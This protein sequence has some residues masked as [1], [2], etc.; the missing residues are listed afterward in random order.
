MC[1]RGGFGTYIREIR[2]KPKI[3]HS[4]ALCVCVGAG[5][6]ELATGDI[7]PAQAPDFLHVFSGLYGASDRVLSGDSGSASEKGSGGWRGNYI[8]KLGSYSVRQVD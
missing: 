7:L 8:Q 3:R 1:G 5:P 4:F 2:F 6:D